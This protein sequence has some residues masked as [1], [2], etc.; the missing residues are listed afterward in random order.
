M[1]ATTP[2][3]QETLKDGRKKAKLFFITW[4]P[5]AAPSRAKMYYTSQK[6]T[7]SIQDV[8][9]GCDE[10]QCSTIEDVAKLLNVKE[11]VEDEEEDWDPDA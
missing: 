11:L 4:T 5:A 10:K 8:F 1:A 6:T 2:T 3:S 9:T 7:K